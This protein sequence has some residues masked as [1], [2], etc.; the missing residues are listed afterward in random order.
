MLWNILQRIVG[1]LCQAFLW[2][3]NIVKQIVEIG[4]IWAHYQKNLNT[5]CLDY[6][7]EI[8]ACQDVNDS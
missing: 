5:L 3:S 7:T 1:E 4:A 2:G 8:K 6:W